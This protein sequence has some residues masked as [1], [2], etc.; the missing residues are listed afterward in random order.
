M[1][2]VPE[3]AEGEE[4]DGE[5]QTQTGEY[6]QDQAGINLLHTDNYQ[7]ARFADSRIAI[8]FANLT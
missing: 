1:D 6:H 3:N 2:P 8:L 5:K 4:D 7:S